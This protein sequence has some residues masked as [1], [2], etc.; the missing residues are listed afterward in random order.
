MVQ[1]ILPNS[2]CNIYNLDRLINQF[3][4]QAIIVV[5][6]LSPSLLFDIEES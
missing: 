5:G 2:T 4:K 1:P 3:Q 6:I